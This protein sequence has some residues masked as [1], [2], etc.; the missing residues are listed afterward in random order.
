VQVSRHQQDCLWG[1]ELFSEVLLLIKRKYGIDNVVQR[2][3]A[4]YL[5]FLDK[6]YGRIMTVESVDYEEFLSYLDIE[7]FLG[8][9]GR[10]TWSSE[11]N[12]SQLM[13]RRAIAEILYDKTPQ[14]LPFLY[15]RFV[16]QLNPDD[17][18]YTFNYDTI[19]ESALESEGI[20]FRLFPYRYTDIGT[21]GNRIDDT[22]TEIV[23]L[24]LHG[25]INWFDRLTPGPAIR[26]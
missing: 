19:L 11:G 2:D 6:C 15:K 7:H 9:K 25:S 12:V 13:I 4:Y 3:L 18:I 8:F 17:Y 22:R 24:K 23:K 21:F 10:D 20:P 16:R 14:T 5:E 26:A 1:N